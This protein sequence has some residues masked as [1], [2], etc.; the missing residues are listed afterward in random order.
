MF[1]GTWGDGGVRVGGISREG[2]GLGSGGIGL[3]AGEGNIGLGNCGG[4][5]CA[6]PGG[7]DV[8]QTSHGTTAAV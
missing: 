5:S 1:E 3:G 8:I 7:A 4:D 2:G 6:T